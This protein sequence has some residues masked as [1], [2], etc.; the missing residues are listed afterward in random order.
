MVNQLIEQI[1]LKLKQVTSVLQRDK[2]YICT[3][4]SCTGGQLAMWLTELDGSS[5]WFERGFVTYSNE[6]KISVLGVEKQ[7]IDTQGAVSEP[8][9]V[10]MAK[11]ALTHSQADIAIAVTGIAGPSGGTQEKP[12]G[13]VCFSVVSKQKE[14]FET[15]WFD[16]SDRHTIRAQSCLFALTMIQQCIE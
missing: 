8:V 3:A 7:L 6:S 13:T 2:K 14:V 12:V 5:N 10:A 4:E 1:Q 11:G 9:A 16:G 15:K